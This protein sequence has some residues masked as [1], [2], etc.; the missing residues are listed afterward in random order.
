MEKIN[1][2][3]KFYTLTNKLKDKIRSGVALWHISK[4]RL[5]SVAEH[6]YGVSMLAIAI[7]SEYDLDIDIK[8]IVLM[9]A[10]HELEECYIGDL[11]PFDNI[12]KEHKKVAGEYAVSQILDGLVKKEE[13]LELTKEYNNKKTK[14]AKFAS[15]CD[16]LEML[17]QMK[18]YEESGYSDMY[19][20]ENTNLL[21]K[22]WIKE[23]INNGATTIADLFFDYHI[24]S[25]DGNEVF[26]NIA[27]Y[28]KNN[29]ITNE[30]YHE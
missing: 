18:I 2:V 1:K 6:V 5:E 30:N 11:T 14:E 20:K 7:D 16:K 29:L 23:L 15:N 9:L 4:D 13:Y 10:I 27:T 21:E 24:P 12:D 8:K 25:F 3:L 19:K 28:A 22:D 26:E 17:L